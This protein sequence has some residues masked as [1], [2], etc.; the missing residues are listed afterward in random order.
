M[1]VMDNDGSKEKTLL[2]PGKKPKNIYMSSRAVIFI[3]KHNEHA[4]NNGYHDIINNSF[5]CSFLLG[6]N[7]I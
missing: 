6:C 7:T 4:L 3:R 1:T 2:L 5:L